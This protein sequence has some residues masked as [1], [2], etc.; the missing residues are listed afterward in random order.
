MKK[1]I[2]I[3]IISFL[4]AINS[5][6]QNEDK[7][8]IVGSNYF[9]DSEILEEQRQVQIYLP[10]SYAETKEKYPVLYLLDGQQYFSHAVSIS[11][12]FKQFKLTPEF[13]IVGI[14]T[15]YPQRYGHF[16]N[17]MDNFIE[18]MEK[19]LIAIVEQ[20]FRTNDERLFFGWQY[21]GSLGFNL[22]ANN[23]IAFDSYILASPFP[24]L[25]KID[26]L[27]NV[28]EINTML[29]FSVSPDE[30][31]VNH[32]TDKLDSLLSSKKIKGLD[33]SY[34]KLL[35]E[36]HHSTGYPTIYHG[37][38]KYFKYYPEFQEDNLQKFIKAGSLD[39]AYGYAKE[40]GRKYG[41]S[42]DLSTW[43]KYTIIRSSIRA[44]D[45]GHFKTFVNEFLTDEFISDLKYRSLDIASFYEK[46]ENYKKAI[47][48]YKVLLT[49]FPDSEGI[50]NKTGSAFMSLDNSVEAEKYF[51]RAKEILETKN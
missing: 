28:S 12:T 26:A 36:E 39:Y 44:N 34:S 8:N 38:R 45:Y 47:D 30:Y 9:I 14:N 13:I 29:Y 1:T 23:T 51:Q 33:W 32:G 2:I 18:F 11:K 22:M 21:A 37:L 3:I 20:N 4:T 49:V 40:R 16:G 42:S 27:D 43:S 24:I 50:L 19:E 31:D 15:S 6:A 5:E 41:F 25:N 17:G 35:S 10:S 48:I 46:N 7:A